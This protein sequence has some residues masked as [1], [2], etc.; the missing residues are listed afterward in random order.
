MRSLQLEKR[1]TGPL[2]IVNYSEV[3]FSFKVLTFNFPGSERI[4]VGAL[5]VDGWNDAKRKF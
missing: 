1:A 3:Q 5:F 2:S 4:G